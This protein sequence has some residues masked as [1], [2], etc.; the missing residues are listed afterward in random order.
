MNQLYE[1]L[2]QEYAIIIKH[3]PFTKERHKIKKEYADYIVD[4]SSNS[5]LNDLLFVTDLL[6]TDYSSVVFEASLL[7]IPM[8]FYVY[9]LKQY[10][11]TRGFYYEFETFVPGK[12]VY[13]FDEIAPIIQAGDFHQEKIDP[14][15]RRFFDGLDG[16]SAKRTADLIYQCAEIE[17]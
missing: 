6:I 11:A 5:E 13:E 8:L 14:F 10:V 9:D 15:K 2:G 3:H 12:I 1:Q 4:M 16:Q 7:D 17:R